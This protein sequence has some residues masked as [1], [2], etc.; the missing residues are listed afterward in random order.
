MQMRNLLLTAILL[1]PASLLVAQDAQYWTYQ[2]GTRA[3]LL[4]GA[5]VGSVLD[6]SATFYNPGGLAL[7]QNPEIVAT[8]RI[9]EAAGVSVDAGADQLLDLSQLR[10]DVAPGFFG[11]IAPFK[12]L[13]DNHVLGYSLF[14]RYYMKS[15]LDSFLTGVTNRPGDNI[16]IDAF[17]E[18]RIHT[19]L[20][21][22]WF[23]LTWSHQVAGPTGIGASMFVTSRSQNGETQTSLQ[24]VAAGEGGAISTR[25]DLYSYWNYGIL[26]KTGVTFEFQKTSLGLTLTTPRLSVVGSGKIVTQASSFGQDLDGDGM[27]DPVF[28]AIVAEGLDATSKSS[29]AF[30]FGASRR[31]GNARLH[32]TAEYFT[33]L[34]TYDILA[35]QSTLAVP[36][37]DTLTTRVQHS[38]KSVFNAGAGAEFTI[39]PVVSG[40]LA[41]RTDFSARRPA[42]PGDVSTSSWDIFFGT[43]GAAFTVGP[44]SIT[45]GL[46]YGGGG[47]LRDITALKESIP[48]R[49]GEL[50]PDELRL[51]YRTMRFIF[52][53]SI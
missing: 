11:G 45:A 40:F 30:A 21:E 15:D 29:W 13:G 35:P 34:D 37:G 22:T 51:R 19:R 5:V 7:I 4:G 3:T 12:F 28:S 16:P 2:Y 27:L 8:S 47:D 46:A 17:G 53:F 20:S 52:A 32:L 1:A 18:M 31:L 41:F 43:V 49:L 26:L 33:A 42:V 23:G 24:G 48:P 44:A 38:L 9:I 10:L 6:I 14:T 50:L 36:T 39:S 25:Q